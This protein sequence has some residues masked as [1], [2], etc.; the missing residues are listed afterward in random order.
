MR[1]MVGVKQVIDVRAPLTVDRRTSAVTAPGTSPNLNRADLCA[2]EA[3]MGLK[4]NSPGIDVL[5]TSIGPADADRVLRY[6]LARGADAA[7]RIW[8]EDLNPGDPYIIA[9]LMAQAARISDCSLLLCGMMSEDSGSAVVPVTVA[10]RL[11][12]PW[13]NRVVSAKL[14]ENGR[15][16]EVLQRGERGGRLEIF[17]DL[18]AVLAFYPGL[19]GHQYVS[20]HRLRASKN[21]PIQV[22]PL[23]QL[24]LEAQEIPGNLPPVKMVKVR[25]PKPRT[26]RTAIASQQLSGE[27]LMWQMMGSGG[28]S[29]KGEDSLVRGEP[30]KLAERILS[31]LTEKGLFHLSMASHRESHQEDSQ[32]K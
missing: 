31:F 19:S 16:V 28:S 14:S 8:D 32:K 10:Q 30:E 11:N 27:E 13:V 12:W 17:C 5:A 3:A 20:S 23:N 9:Q 29:R 7:W 25:Q 1:V 21:R 24:G 6:S 15:G 18:P 26:K 22:Y 2:L 4:K